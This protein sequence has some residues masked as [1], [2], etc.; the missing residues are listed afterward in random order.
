MNFHP[1]KCPSC[2][3]QLQLPEDRET[4]R[5][6]Y[7][8]T[9]IIVSV[10]LG[11]R[12]GPSLSTILGL[13]RAA[14]DAD[15]HEEAY[16]YFS[17]ALELDS[18]HA[19]AWDGKGEATGWLSKLNDIRIKEASDCFLRALSLTSAECKSGYAIDASERLCSMAIATYKIIQSYFFDFV[20]QENWHDF[21]AQSAL[22]LRVLEIAYEMDSS[23]I[24]ALE[25]AVV[26]CRDNLAGATYWASYYG[27]NRQF[28][29]VPT[30]DREADLQKVFASAVS[31]IRRVKPSYQPPAI[32]KPYAGCMAKTVYLFLFACGA[33]WYAIRCL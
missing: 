13:G 4:V 12:S 28:R 6:M 2:S 32:Q 22:L 16:R 17:R 8:G 31:R 15:N 14:L 29:I 25:V 27:D 5:C 9:E 10:A 20:S 23:N 21:I 11:S 19:E 33:V 24:A 3:G 18:K 30:P 26:I 1:A 7:C